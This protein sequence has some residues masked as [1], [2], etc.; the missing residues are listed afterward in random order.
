M[1]GFY[2][3]RSQIRFDLIIDFNVKNRQQEYSQILEECRKAYPDHDV[4][5]T[6][7]ADVSDLHGD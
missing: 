5:I 3:D 6:L 2:A 7:D 1:H 4:Q